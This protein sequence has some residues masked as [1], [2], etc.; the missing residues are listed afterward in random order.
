VKTRL[1]FG[2]ALTLAATIATH[3]AVQEPKTASQPPSIAGTYK[4]ASRLLPDGTM[5]RPPEIM[6]LLT[7]TQTHRN[8]NVFWKDAAGK[9]FSCSI[10]STYSLTPT[11]YTETLLFSVLNDQIGG[12]EI[13]YDLS[14]K[15]ATAAVKVDA[16]RIEIKLPFDPPTVVFGADRLTA[17]AEGQFVDTWEKVQ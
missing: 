17:T 16:G 1:L 6:G 10:A 8:F 5:H 9:I 2:S 7:Y 15:T 11:L 13:A 12:K 14:G 4:L 3:G